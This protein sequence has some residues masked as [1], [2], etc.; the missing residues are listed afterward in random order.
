VLPSVDQRSTFTSESVSE[1]LPEICDKISDAILDAFI[2]NHV[3]LGIADGSSLN[4]RL[5]IS[6]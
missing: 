4:T 6:L 3:K 5:A 1:G 2:A